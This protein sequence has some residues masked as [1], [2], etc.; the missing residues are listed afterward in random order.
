MLEM[1]ARICS[2]LMLELLEPPAEV[3]A[4]GLNNDGLEPPS[5]VC[6]TGAP[7]ATPNIRLGDPGDGAMLRKLLLGKALNALLEAAEDTTVGGTAVPKLRRS[8]NWLDKP[9]K[10]S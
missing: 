3:V 7:G 5:G 10:G 1:P 6:D 9:P 4:T 8:P 2:I